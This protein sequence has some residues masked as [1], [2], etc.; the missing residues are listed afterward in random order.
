MAREALES[1]SA[2]FDWVKHERDRLVKWVSQDGR[3][4]RIKDLKD[5]HLLHILLLIDKRI[6]ENPIGPNRVGKN[7]V[8]IFYAPLLAEIEK[9]GLATQYLM[10][11]GDVKSLVIYTANK[12]KEK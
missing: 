9:R 4:T 8:S 10:R 2:G 6:D 1:V 5:D 7:F 3:Q 11:R 12:H